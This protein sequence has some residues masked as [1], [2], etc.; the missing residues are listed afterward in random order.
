M[1]GMI[2]TGILIKY[3]LPPRTGDRLAIWGMGRHDWGDIHF[4]LSLGLL[5]LLLLHVALH[6]SWVCTVA[7]K[8]FSHT[9]GAP[10]PVRRWRRDLYG[11]L[12]L[13]AFAALIGGFQWIAVA[14][15]RE[16][17]KGEGERH[18]REYRRQASREGATFGSTP[19]R[20]R[21]ADAARI[22]G[23]MTLDE[24]VRTSGMSADRVR[25]R[26]HLPD[27]VSADARLGKLRKVY[28]FRMSDVRDLIRESNPGFMKPAETDTGDPQ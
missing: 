24:F 8:M 3:A 26:L 1:L 23:A 17:T 9:N 28:G 20:L 12:T 5:A 16:A 10:K 4:W 14:N 7:Q 27:D 13:A 15:I 2:S 21:S 11:I 18:S 19:R 6:W 25:E 22:N